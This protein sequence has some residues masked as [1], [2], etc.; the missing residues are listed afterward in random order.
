M[1]T[2]DLQRQQTA[3]NPSPAVQAFGG[4][5]S[6][7][8]P[9]RVNE[10]AAKATRGAGSPLPHLEAIQRSFGSHSVR[11]VKVHSDPLARRTALSMG[12]QAFAYG[13]SIAF[14]RSPSLYEAAHEAAHVVQQR[15]GRVPS[16]SVSEPGD[17]HEALADQV[18]SRVVS[19]QSATDLLPSAAPN[20]TGGGAPS[21]Q[22]MVLRLGS[23]ERGGFLDQEMSGVTYHNPTAQATIPDKWGMLGKRFLFGAYNPN[24]AQPRKSYRPQNDEQRVLRNMGATEKLNIIAHGSRAFNRIGGYTPIKM[25]NL[26]V[27]LGLPNGYSGDIEID[28][29]FGAKERGGTTFIEQLYLEMQ[30]RGYA[31]D[32]FG[33]R[34]VATGGGHLESSLESLNAHE[35]K[36]KMLGQ[37]D[38]V[39]GMFQ[40]RSNNLTKWANERYN[41]A[42]R[43]FR[44]VENGYRRGRN[45]LSA[46]TLLQNRPQATQPQP[47]IQLES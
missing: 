1:F 16:G 14:T 30:K 18:A 7:Q 33:I 40:G 23:L 15:S 43:E 17:R 42:N 19:G 28:G 46:R 12:A 10:A 21:V 9:V 45:W 25:A 34:G 32:V 24:Q 5:V 35:K 4:F 3:P 39:V 27:N 41:T 22:R 29:C 38:W 11:D 31:C 8:S 20:G 44:Q 2:F 6:N 13:N 37:R 36:E 26:L 47:N